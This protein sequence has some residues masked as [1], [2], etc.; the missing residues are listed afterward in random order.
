MC[1]CVR[2]ST[3]YNHV[4]V[5]GGKS[6]YNRVCVRVFGVVVAMNIDLGGHTAVECVFVCAFGVSTRYTR[7]CGHLGGHRRRVGLCCPPLLDYLKHLCVHL[8]KMCECVRVCV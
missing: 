8:F 7:V 3:S 2:G 1:V 5:F 4:C 6:T